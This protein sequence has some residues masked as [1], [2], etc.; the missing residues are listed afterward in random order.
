MVVD[1]KGKPLAGDVHVEV[2]YPGQAGG[3]ANAVTY[4]VDATGILMIPIGPA[5]FGKATV[6]IIQLPP[7]YLT[8]ADG[9]LTLNPGDQKVQFVVGTKSDLYASGGIAAGMLVLGVFFL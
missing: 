1:A 8:P 4:P 9:E 5:Q 3:N 7:G 6:K 2:D